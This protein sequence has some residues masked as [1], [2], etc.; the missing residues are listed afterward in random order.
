MKNHKARP[1]LIESKDIHSQLEIDDISIGKLSYE[2]KQYHCKHPQELILISLEDEK[3]EVGDEF[4]S[5]KYE[6]TD[7]LASN[8]VIDEFTSFKVIAR[9]SQISP[10]YISK[11]IEQHNNDC[12]EDFK[13][14]IEELYF[15]GSGFYKSE[16]LSLEEQEKYSFMKEIKPKLTN[17]FVTIVEEETIQFY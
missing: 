2:A 16:Q 14:E 3:I 4:Y 15:H 8:G 9:Q 11:F 12:V 5:S 7:V 13:I 1:V 17:G 6:T 10:E